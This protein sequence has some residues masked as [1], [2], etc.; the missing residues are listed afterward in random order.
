MLG[1]KDLELTEVWVDVEDVATANPY[2]HQH[3]I[4][5]CEQ[6]RRILGRLLCELGA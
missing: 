3:E 2:T 4:G 6:C 1:L 5:S